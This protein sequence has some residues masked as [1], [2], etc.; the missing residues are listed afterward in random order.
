M[1]KVTTGTYIE[2]TVA[3]ETVRAF[4]PNPL[5]PKLTK[6]DLA[7][8][9]EPIRA[10]EAALERLRLAGEM[11]PSIDWFVYSFVR[12]EALLTS[13]IEGTQATLAD[14]MSY[15]QTG[16]PGASDVADVE[17][18]SNYVRATNY[19]FDQLASENGLP[20]STRLLNE[21]HHKLMHGI[22]GQD[23]QPGEIR[24]SQVWVGGTRPGNAIFVP[25][26]WDQVRDLLGALETYIHSDD[27]LPPLLR[28]AAAHVQFETIHPYLD[29]NGR[30][31]RLLIALLLAHW[32]VLET[33]L[34]YL[35]VYLKEHQA[36]YYEQLGSIRKSGAW[37][38]WFRFFL[39]GIKKVATNAAAT[40]SALNR[41]V[42]NDRKILLSAKSITVSAI[43]LFELLPE[44]PVISMPVVT[45][46]LDTTKPTAGKAIELLQQYGVL[47]VMGDRK[48]D[49]TYSYGPYLDILTN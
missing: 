8:L 37:T 49:R 3:G 12:K 22:R 16:Q 7:S 30:L 5:P 42:N 4:V 36:E 19:A 15:E 29:G 10:A 34:L 33:P 39:E 31:G 25:P 46:L 18:V 14:V 21:C 20:V 23:K 1:S 44:H 45:Q 6:K 17:E 27:D 48:R 38:D 32:R 47:R 11:I 13:E 26:P 9:Q 35:S 41:Q 40:A 2:T 24:R 28:I 43:Q